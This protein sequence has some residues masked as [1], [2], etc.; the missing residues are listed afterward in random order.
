MTPIDVMFGAPFMQQAALALI[1]LAICGAVVGVMLNLRDLE[2]VSD[3]LVHAVFPG[4]VIGLALGGSEAVYVGAIIAALIATV[5]LTIATN[6]GVGTD[7]STAVLLAGA[8]ALGI[9]IVSRTT[10]YSTGVE[11]L[12]FGQLLTIGVGDIVIIA[13]LGV[14]ALLLVGLTW[15]EQLFISFD[16]RGAE[17]T[18]MRV[19]AFELALNL[20][21][22]LVV[23]AAS[24]AVGNLLVLAVLIVPAAVGRLLARRIGSIVLIAVVTALVG[25]LAGLVGGYWFAVDA[26][27]AVSPSGVLVLVLVAIYLVVAGVSTLATRMRGGRRP[28]VTDPFVQSIRGASAT[29][30]LA[31]AGV[32]VGGAIRSNPGANVQGDL[33]GDENTGE[34]RA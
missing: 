23:V 20:A 8:F 26:R 7:A 30:E 13:V 33:V 4:V 6:R 2:F 3:G 19:F 24:R 15:K 10:T 27:L 22:A 21:I 9:V 14:L 5:L 25:S 34:A 12:L 28:L 31:G 11:Q 16:R 29:A 1:L 17:A 18:G 32:A